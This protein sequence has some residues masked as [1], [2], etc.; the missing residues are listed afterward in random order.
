MALM[1][2]REPNARMY[3][4]VAAVGAANKI[5]PELGKE[6]YTG[7]FANPN[8]LPCIGIADDRGICRHF[9][10]KLFHKVHLCRWVGARPCA[11][12]RPRNPEDKDAVLH[13]IITQWHLLGI[14]ARDHLMIELRPQMIKS[15]LVG[16]RIGRPTSP[17]IL[18]HR[19]PKLFC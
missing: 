12:N 18:L 1:K 15:P 14:G 5:A 8:V 4:E 13:K 19:K 3:A 17:Q 7:A 10:E 11:I 9:G 16:L 2:I 6:G